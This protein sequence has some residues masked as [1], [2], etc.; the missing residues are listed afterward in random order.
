M[1]EAFRG[2][3]WEKENS[4]TVDGSPAYKYV[5][6][7]VLITDKPLALMKGETEVVLDGMAKFYEMN[8]FAE[9]LHNFKPFRPAYRLGDAS[10][11]LVDLEDIVGEP[12]A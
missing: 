8:S 3:V 2:V 6:V 1:R 7:G 5:I 9:S 11:V 10:S 4:T 12:L